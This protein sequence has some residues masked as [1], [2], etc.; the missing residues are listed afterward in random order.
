MKYLWKIG[1]EAGFG[2]MTAGYVLGKIA[3]RSGYHVYNYAEYPSL[4]RGGHNTYE[5]LISPEEVG[6][7]KQPID[8]LLCLNKDTFELQ[9]HRLHTLSKVVYDPS[10]FPAEGDFQKIELPFSTILKELKG[11]AMTMNT[12]ALGATIAL[13]KGDIELLYSIIESEF[14]RKGTQV[15]EYNKNFAKKGY[16]H[17][18]H[19]YASLQQDVLVKRSDKEKVL[20]SGN[21]A[22]SFAAVT[23]DCRLY[24]AYPMTPTSNVLSILAAWQNTTGMV[25]R[26][27]EDEISVI[28]TA[29]GASHAGV[30]TAVGTSGGG[31]A[32]MVETISYAGVAEIPIVILLGMRPGP[33]T[34]MPTWTEQ[35]D[36]LFACY[37]GH[38]EFPKVVLA[39]GDIL[40]MVECTEKAF[41]LADKY[42]MPVI[43]LGDKLLLESYKSELHEKFSNVVANHLN[44]RG[45]TVTKPSSEPFDS[46]QGKPYLRYQ[47]SEDGISERLIPGY[48]GAFYQANSYEHTQDG[49][50]SE[51][52]QD[53]VEQVNK[54]SKKIITYFAKDF[55]VPSVYG[56]VNESETVFVSWGGNKGTILE[57]QTVL[58]EKGVNT[59]Y[60]HFT[61][62]HPLDREKII[63]FFPEGKRYILVENNSTGQF[64][65]LLQMHTGITITEKLLKYDGRPFWVEDIVSYIW[66][67]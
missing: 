58:K 35:G 27:A 22:F 51:E 17:I 14:S 23:A 44:D 25:V 29:L 49:H 45:K 28:N 20:L 65:Q 34:G 2:V 30:R 57:A 3:I 54:R 11:P 4:I 13:L 61:H 43:V 24:S 67:K 36:L 12:V 40:E 47:L 37:G 48:E 50:T 46:A 41:N 16:E 19:N 59:A 42:Q 31:F 32:L 33:A 63:P 39:P 38:G 6:A 18:V 10:A 5:V 55:A 21:E 56:S 1:G 64:G 52:A 26:H 7:T 9:K 66:Q 15:V 53:R 62:V 8:L 60:I